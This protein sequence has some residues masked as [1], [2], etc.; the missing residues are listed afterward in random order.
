MTARR[1]LLYN[2]KSK[3]ITQMVSGRTVIMAKE[4]KIT[5]MR[6]KE[7]EDELKY[8][9]TVREAEVAEQIKEARSF[10]DL[11]ENSEYDE[12]KNEQAKLYGRIAEVENIL[13]HAVII[14]ETEEATGRIS[15]GC[16]IKVLDTDSGE[17]EVYT[18]VG[19]QEADPMLG[20]ISDDSPFG[21]ALV[22]HKEGEKV[23][24]EAPI[25]VL[26][27]EILSVQK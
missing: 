19:S 15:L 7:L 4:F 6:L 14:D 5:T 20:K 1:I 11:S 21:R 10:G 18:I 23:A 16:T 27:F 22:G 8:L 13:A 2:H 12:A 26:T 3:K 24:V 9:K 25:G 17:T